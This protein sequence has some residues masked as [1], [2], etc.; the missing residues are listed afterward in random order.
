MWIDST[1]IPSEYAESNNNFTWID[2][3]TYLNVYNFNNSS[4]LKVYPNP[5]NN[6]LTIQNKENISENFDYKIVDLTGRI[7]KS[8]NSKFNE[9]INEAKSQELK[10]SLEFMKNY[11]L[12]KV[13]DDKIEGKEFSSD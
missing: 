1:I 4:E 12:E 10:D 11:V 2:W 3:V 13:S 8:G 5:S 9:Q 6:F 7:V